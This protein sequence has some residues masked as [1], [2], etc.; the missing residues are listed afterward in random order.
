M[1]D[2]IFLGERHTYGGFAAPFSLPL[3]DL[4]RHAYVI[5]KSGTGKSTLL[6]LF[7]ERLI[8]LGHGVGLIDPHG[9]LAAQVLAA[10]PRSRLDD[11]VYLNLADEEFAPSLNFVSD[12][13]PV[14][15]RPRLASALVAAFRHLWASSWGPRLEHI[16]YH[17]LRVLIDCQN[18]S[19]V[20]LPRLLTD[21]VFRAW[22]VGQ[23]KDPFIREFWQREYEGWDRRFRAEAI[24][25][26]L[27]KL[28]QLAAFP[29]LRQALGQV[30]MKVDVPGILDQGKIL[31]VNLAKGSLGEDA[32]RLLGALIAASLS[33]AAMER[34][35]TS[36]GGRKDFTL[37][38]DEAHCF[39]S[40]GM[41]AVLSE[42]RKFG[43]R[44]IIAHQFLGQLAPPLR[45]A[46]LGNVGS[47]FAFRVSG[48]DAEVLS[49]NYGGAVSAN[50]FADLPPFT[51][52]LRPADGLTQPVRLSLARLPN[53]ETGYTHA[54]IARS[55]QRYCSPRKEV[56]DKLR[57]WLRRNDGSA[58]FYE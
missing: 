41:A 48:E 55:R 30:K 33:A 15:A 51:T 29:P 46:V 38:M 45:E 13:V 39:L 36:G 28:G 43:L 27:N 32:A 5:G 10:V 54:I 9:D 40:E 18:T 20:A 37:I 6:Q 35:S 3:A 14:E 16:L 44:L 34:S 11:V 57:R 24:A 12:A 17:S 21:D 4:A 26:V 50:L 8:Q 23:C 7:A 53:Q 47:I 22:V 42:S 52:L 49:A 31:I 58:A 19:L 25:P 56:E 2:D 1:N